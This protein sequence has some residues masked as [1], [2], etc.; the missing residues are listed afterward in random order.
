MDVCAGAY[1]LEEDAPPQA[2]SMN[3]QNIQIAIGGSYC[4]GTSSQALHILI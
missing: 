4:L 3:I 1:I 2:C